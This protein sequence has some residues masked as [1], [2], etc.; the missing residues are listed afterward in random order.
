MCPRPHPLILQ[1]RPPPRPPHH[2]C[3]DQAGQGGIG[4]AGQERSTGVHSGLG[5]TGGGGGGGS[6]GGGGGAGAALVVVVGAA[7]V[8][9]PAGAALLQEVAG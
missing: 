5:S 7:L 3:S 2:A 4:H 1:G 6:T 9:V 8:V